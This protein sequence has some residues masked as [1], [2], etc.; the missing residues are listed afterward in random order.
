MRR[1]AAAGA[2]ALALLA[3]SSIPALA[4]PSGTC[5]PATRGQTY[6][7]VTLEIPL[8]NGSGSVLIDSRFGWDGTSVRPNCDGPTQSIRTRNTGTQSAWAVLPDKKKAPHWVQIDPGTD[9]TVS[10]QG[11]LNNLGLT[12]YSDVVSVG[13]AFTQPT[14]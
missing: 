6:N 5:D 10:A 13:F 9:V 4:A 14:Q 1:I 11:Q 2:L 3:G 12:S 8:P 7:Q